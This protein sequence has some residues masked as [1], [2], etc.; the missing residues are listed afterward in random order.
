LLGLRKATFDMKPTVKEKCSE[1]D[2][3]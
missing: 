3:S 2:S 1:S